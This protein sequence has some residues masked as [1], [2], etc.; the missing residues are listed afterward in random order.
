MLKDT[1]F[2][3]DLAEQIYRSHLRKVGAFSAGVAM[4]RKEVKSVK[5]IA[6]L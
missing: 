5:G 4:D 1:D 2:T 3:R 6:K